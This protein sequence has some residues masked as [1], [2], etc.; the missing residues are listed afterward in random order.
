MTLV[1]RAGNCRWHGCRLP[2]TNPI[3]RTRG[4]AHLKPDPLSQLSL[5]LKSHPR[6]PFRY[7]FH[8]LFSFIE[9][10]SPNFFSSLFAVSPLLLSLLSLFKNFTVP[11]TPLD[12]SYSSCPSTFYHHILRISQVVSYYK[13][14]PTTVISIYSRCA[15]QSLPEQCFCLAFLLV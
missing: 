8:P 11:D 6:S 7:S 9:A 2:S 12:I 1:S 13:P 14:T 10:H 4:Q 15:T 5:K 3:P